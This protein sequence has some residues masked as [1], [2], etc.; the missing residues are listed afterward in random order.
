MPQF[1]L[2]G[3]HSREQLKSCME[4]RPQSALLAQTSCWLHQTPLSSIPWG[5]LRSAGTGI[6]AMLQSIE[7]G[8]LVV[9]FAI[10]AVL[11]AAM[12]NTIS[13]HRHYLCKQRPSSGIARRA[14]WNAHFTAE[15]AAQPQTKP[16]TV[17]ELLQHADEENAEHGDPSVV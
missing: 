2:L 7:T 3:Q 15:S 12:A 14:K 11:A 1:T 6:A 16:L 4:A 5:F 9:T 10:F 8:K 17:A 13:K